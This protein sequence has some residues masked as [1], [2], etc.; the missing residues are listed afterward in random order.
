MIAMVYRPRWISPGHTWDMGDE[1]G[2]RQ[3]LDEIIAEGGDEL[4]AEA[5]KLLE[6]IGS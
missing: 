5:H 1:D 4:T 2:A 6:R 3:I